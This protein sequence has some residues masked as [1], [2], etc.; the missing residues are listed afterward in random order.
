MLQGNVFQPS[1]IC[2]TLR[3]TKI[4]YS[5]IPKEDISFQHDTPFG[6]TGVIAKGLVKKLSGSY[7]FLMPTNLQTLPPKYDS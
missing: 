7:F 4:S 3:T 2:A 1:R 6:A 5:Q